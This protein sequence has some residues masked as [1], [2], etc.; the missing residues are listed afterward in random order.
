MHEIMRRIL[1]PVP[2]PWLRHL[3]YR[4]RFG[5]WGNFRHPQ[6]FTEHLTAR[7]LYDRSE[8]LAWTCDKLQMKAH[9]ARLCA[10]L[11]VPGTLW[12][13]TDLDQ[14]DMEA[15]P[16]E[17]VIKPNHRSGLV[18]FGNRETSRAELKQVTNGWLRMHDRAAIGEWAYRRASHELIIESRFGSQNG[19]AATDYK[20]FV[21]H[22]EVKLLHCDAGRFTDDFRE[23]F[24]SPQWEELDIY[25]GVETRA[26]LPAPVSLDQMVA[27]AQKLAEGFDFMRV[28]LYEI[29]G[30]PWFGELT[31]YPSGGMDPFE[32]DEVDMMMGRWWR[33]DVMA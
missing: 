31:P 19:G 21:F 7:M 22:G 8:D 2:D 10:D 15:L 12:H 6:R 4:R 25:N 27:Y 11:D 24:Y 16:E 23:T 17:W 14:L 33:Q 28:D 9:A 32:P 5:Y 29:D 26:E 1:S 30:R 18:F 3:M 13:G 20:F